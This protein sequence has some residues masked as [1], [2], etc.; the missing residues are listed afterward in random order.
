MPVRVGSCGG[1]V[2]V[3]SAAHSGPRRGR[4]AAGRRGAFTRHGVGMG[5]AVRMAL[6][7]RG[8]GDRWPA[9]DGGGLAR[10]QLFLRAV[11]VDQ[12]CRDV[13]RTWP[14][15]RHGGRWLRLR[16][17]RGGGRRRR[18]RRL[19]HLMVAIGRQRRRGGF[20]EL[21]C[22][23]NE[24]PQLLATPRLVL[25]LEL[26][27]RRRLS[28]SVPCLL[29]LRRGRHFCCCYPSGCWSRPRCKLRHDDWGCRRRLLCWSVFF[30]RHLARGHDFL[31]CRAIAAWP[32]HCIRPDFAV[33]LAPPVSARNTK[34]AARQSGALP[35]C[36]HALS[37][38]H[39]IR[40]DTSILTGL[41][42][43]CKHRGATDSAPHLSSATLWTTCQIFAF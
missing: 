41:S 7:R 14:R 13:A 22:F 1:R 30:A 38:W 10:W 18:L 3:A 28:A 17:Q 37:G 24:L 12:R 32:S 39:T 6:G 27:L 5:G 15:P 9:G 35:A 25:A 34:I 8:H 29:E 23:R 31:R 20:L 33:V 42:V 2:P 4:V 11:K 40:V 43:A 16:L 19:L 26:E 21:T 36:A